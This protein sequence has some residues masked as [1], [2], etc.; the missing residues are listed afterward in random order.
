MNGFY[1]LIPL[2]VSVLKKFK[3]MFD[4][5]L[6]FVV[7]QSSSVGR[8]LFLEHQKDGKYD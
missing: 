5:V 2:L 7:I 6:V 3:M 4:R 1:S 8:V